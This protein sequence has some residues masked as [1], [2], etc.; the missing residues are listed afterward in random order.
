L[1]TLHALPTLTLEEIQMQK[2]IIALAVAGLVSGAAFAQSNVTLYGRADLS[3][4]YSKSDF[5]KFQGIENGK[6][7]GG[8]PSR[9][10]VQG[11]EGL[12]N[13]LKAIFKFEWAVAADEGGGPVGARFTYVGLGG[14][15]GAVTVGRD[16][17]PSDRYLGTTG[18]YGI[19]GNEPINLFRGSMGTAIA[20]TRWNN[21]ISYVSPNF[22]GLDFTT[23]YAFGEQVN[24]SDNTGT[25]YNGGYESADTTDANLFG[26]GVRYANGPLYL[27]AVYQAQED[28][29]GKKPFGVSSNAGYGAKSWSLGGTYD[30]KVVKL[31]AN[32]LRTKANHSGLAYGKNDAGSDKQTAWSLGLGIPVSSA[33]T[34]YTEYAQ[35]K[36]SLGGYDS[37]TNTGYTRNIQNGFIGRPGDKAKGYTLGYR[38]NLSKRTWLYTYATRIDNDRGI[39]TGWDKTRVAG[40]K[41]TNFTT[42]IVHLF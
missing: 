30:F 10:G 22:S 5:R 37:A 7:I 34:V 26:F 27:T 36:D 19:N 33:G 8:G 32:Y 35:Y 2:K 14:K 31:Y 13:G 21:S 28:N 11:E 17:N 3:Y 16:S 40:E 18:I 15:F 12:G 29:D 38:H 1:A 4:N 20:G 6:G 39:E 41:Q 9:L 42:G 23:S 25:G 24:S